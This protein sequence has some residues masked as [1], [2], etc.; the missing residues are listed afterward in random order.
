MNLKKAIHHSIL[1]SRPETVFGPDS[2]YQQLYSL[3]VGETA[4]FV[5]EN[6]SEEKLKT[7]AKKLEKVSGNTIAAERVLHDHFKTIPMGEVR[8]H[9]RINYFLSQSK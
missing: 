2:A 4:R 1:E 9:E 6:L 3:L 8:L 7:F 5:A